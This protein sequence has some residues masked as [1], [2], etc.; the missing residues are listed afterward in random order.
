MIQLS[1]IFIPLITLCFMTISFWHVTSWSFPRAET[2]S[3]YVSIQG[4]WKFMVTSQILTHLDCWLKANNFWGQWGKT[5]RL[6]CCILKSSSCSKW[7]LGSSCPSQKCTWR[8]MLND[9]SCNHPC[10]KGSATAHR[11][12]GSNIELETT[13][14]RK[15]EELQLILANSN[16]YLLLKWPSPPKE[17]AKN[18]HFLKEPFLSQHIHWNSFWF[19][20]I[21][22]NISGIIK[23]F[24]EE[25][26]KYS[27]HCTRHSHSI[28]CAWLRL[29]LF[30]EDI[31]KFNRCGGELWPCR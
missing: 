27:H 28:Y 15:E 31:L 30:K 9:N 8:E 1:V 16:L 7:I 21:M 6:S 13:K 26:R 25:I 10:L 19:Y 20:N 24:Q 29:T 4:P 17:N 18:S 3:S 23:V 22:C 14:Q 2:M 11:N 5:T 12:T